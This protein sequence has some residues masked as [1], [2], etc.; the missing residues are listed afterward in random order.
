[1]QNGWTQNN[2]HFPGP[3]K[4]IFQSKCCH[5]TFN[6]YNKAHNTLQMIDVDNFYFSQCEWYHISSHEAKQSWILFEG[7]QWR[8]WCRRKYGKVIYSHYY[9]YCYH[10][11][12]TLTCQH[13]N[14]WE[15]RIQ[16]KIFVLL[17]HGKA[18]H[19]SSIKFAHT[20]HDFANKIYFVYYACAVCT[21]L[22]FHWTTCYFF[23][24]ALPVIIT[25]S[26]TL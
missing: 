3:K 9:Y 1:M 18:A 19:H 4:Y 14:G 11:N 16:L 8:L 24:F 26:K 5:H 7:L 2:S 22:F 23:F 10:Y 20:L 13:L 12:L 17:I 6:M 15:M 25:T 21:E